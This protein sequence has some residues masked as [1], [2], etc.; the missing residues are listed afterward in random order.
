VGTEQ[1]LPAESEPVGHRWWGLDRRSLLPAAVVLAIG[2]V[3][4]VLLPLVDRSVAEPEVVRAGGRLDLG[5]GLTVAPPEGWRVVRGVMASTP[6]TVPVPA[7]GVAAV[8]DGAV[9]AAFPVAPYPGTAWQLLD[10]MDAIRYHTTVLPG[11]RVAGDRRQLTGTGDVSGVLE[12]Y[13]STSGVGVVA[14]YVLPDGRGLTILVSAAPAAQLPAR[15]D[16]IER[17]LASIALTTEGARP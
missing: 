1:G 4:A 5:R 12:D 9:T 7:M 3:L 13:T 16:R 14:A 6:T 2:L 10:Q 8:T 11:F 17:M 15:T